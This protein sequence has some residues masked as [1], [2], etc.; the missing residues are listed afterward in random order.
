MDC[1]LPAPEVMVTPALLL[2]SSIPM[3]PVPLIVWAELPANESL[4]VDAVTDPWL[5]R[6]PVN[7]RFPLPKA[8][9]LPVSNVKLASVTDVGGRGVLLLDAG[10]MTS[11]PLVGTKAGVQLAAV[12]QSVLTLPFQVTEGVKVPLLVNV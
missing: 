5:M 11:K 2:I 7:V 1:I 8:S 6:L 12:F 9:V 3:V 4:P 10:M